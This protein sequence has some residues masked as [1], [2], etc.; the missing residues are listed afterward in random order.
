MDNE[1]YYEYFEVGKN[2]GL[3]EKHALTENDLLIFKKLRN[4]EIKE[5]K[6][7]CIIITI[8]FAI[9]ILLAFTGDIFSGMIFLVVFSTIDFFAIKHHFN[10]KNFEPEYC[11]Y[12]IVTDKFI[13]KEK[14]DD[15][16]YIIINA[17]NNLIKFKRNFNEYNA[18]EIND[19]VVLFAIKGRNELLFDKKI[20]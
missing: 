10:L 16:R 3:I 8:F 17:N 19:E 14:G 7:G 4:Y 1:K 11:D 2:K 6:K 15:D 12:G 20:Y 18:I 13:K 9:I 5:S